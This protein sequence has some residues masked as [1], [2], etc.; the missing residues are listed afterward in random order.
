MNSQHQSNGHPRARR[1]I[2]L[3]A[4]PFEFISQLAEMESWRK[5][6]YR[7]IYHIHKWWAKRLGSVFRGILLGSALPDSE[8]LVEAFY[9]QHDF[10]GLMVFDPFMGSGTTIGEAHKLGFTALGR[11]IN[12]VACESVRVSLGPLNRDALMKA[13]GQLSASVGERI[14]ALYQTADAEGHVCDAL[15]FF[16]VKTLPCPAC[17]ANVDLFPT[18]IFVR[19][20]YPD[21]KPE[22]RVVCPECAGIF[23]ADVNDEKS[24]CPHCQHDFDLHSGP[25][26]G[27]SATC[28]KCHHVFPI[29]K[30][31][32]AIGHPPAHRMFAKLVLNS[33]GEKLYL[34][35]TRKDE[36]A[37]QRCSEELHRSKLPLPTLELKD[38]YNTRQVLN[39][40]YRS[41]REFF[42]D[43]QLLA[44]GW[45]HA[46]ILELPDDATR[47]ALRTVF[48]GVL[49][50]NNMFASYKGEGTGA[51]RHMF[52][53]HILKPERVPIEGNVWGT[54]K[55]SGSFSTLFKSRLLR[56][57]EY[58]AAPF[59][60]EI[61]RT[62][63]SSNGKRVFGG[64]APFSGRVET[65]WPPPPK[66]ASRAIYLSC[67]S[68]AS[69]G[70]ADASVDL[71]VTDPPFF[72]NVHYSELADFFFAWQQ[73]GPSPFVGKRS[74]TRHVEEVQDTSAE[75]FAAK[76]SAVFAECCRVLREDGLLVF[77]YHHSRMD[78]W[79]SLADAVVGAGFSLVNCHPVKSEMS[80]AAPK[81][82][83]K[84]PIQLDVVLV[85]RKQIADIRKRS[86]TK[87]AFQRAVERAT[88]KASRLKE[89]GLALS[90]ND[91]RVILISQFLVET[92][93]GRSAEHLSNVLLSS[94]TDLDLA[95]MR[96]L[97]SQ[98]T[99]PANQVKRD[100]K[101][102]ALLDKKR[103]KRPSKD[104]KVIA[105]PVTYRR[106]Q[107]RL[108]PKAAR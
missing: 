77:T 43:R 2:E 34:P 86:D 4:F 6:V 65:K 49:E 19:N 87:N 10:T 47:A 16:W 82:Q 38:G 22:V 102:L 40:A 108:H 32:K 30:T 31:A 14:R 39:Y 21:R 35:V 91:R 83:T 68:S 79:T 85:C 57:I 59:E 18:Y 50:F 44:L 88:S 76:L 26:S 11:D 23:A 62:N 29:A 72:D 66:P 13:F 94:L 53:H 69:T 55:S 71:V 1:L 99:Q 45:L 46:A 67:G 63:G 17:S 27:A 73:L 15:Y 84:E 103:T 58:H 81:S 56:A 107:Q 104:V 101:Q 33:S 61:E 97:E 106:T 60:L 42:N 9:R 96:L 36:L 74:T 92:C 80:V 98:A 25:A 12:P 52:A 75:Q 41:W 28:R 95:A 5:E 48:S 93:A 70:L 78:G 8:N 105:T 7:P 100:E 3:D 24:R 64:S 20:A 54:S 90:V 89:C 51:I 37:Y